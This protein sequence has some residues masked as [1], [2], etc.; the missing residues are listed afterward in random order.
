M[1][2]AGVRSLNSLAGREMRILWG[3]AVLQS[4]AGFSDNLGKARRISFSDLRK[5]GNKLAGLAFPKYPKNTGR[6]IRKMWEEFRTF[7][8][9]R[10]GTCS[11]ESRKYRK[12]SETWWK[13]I[14]A[15]AGRKFC[16]VCWLVLRAWPC[17]TS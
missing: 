9:I 11:R 5:S 15:P 14:L 6:N 2:V 10:E 1:C 13:S 8:K 17:R 12:E 7:R 16:A 4:L 3:E